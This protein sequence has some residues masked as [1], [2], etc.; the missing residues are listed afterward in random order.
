MIELLRRDVVNYAPLKGLLL[1]IT[2]NGGSDPSIATSYNV[3][4]VTRTGIGVYRVT[5]I[6]NTIFGFSIGSNSA[7]ALSHSIQPSVVSEAHFVRVI[8]VSPGI[9]DIEV[10]ELTVGGG[11]KLEVNPYDI[12]SSDGVDVTFLINAGLGKLPPE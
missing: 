7:I 11:N 8:A 3:L 1:A 5:A 12:L 10:T 4:T 9:F 2:G 6:Q